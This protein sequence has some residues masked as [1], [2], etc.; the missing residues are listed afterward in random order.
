MAGGNLITYASSPSICIADLDMAKL[1]WNSVISK[2]GA[3]Y[4]CLDIIFLSHCKIGVYQILAHAPGI[5]SYLDS[6]TI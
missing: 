2:K 5:I 3:K 1:H 6:G 4:M